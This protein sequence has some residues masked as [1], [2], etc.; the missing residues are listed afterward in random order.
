MCKIKLVIIVHVAYNVVELGCAKIN[1]YNH[2]NDRPN[3][4]VSKKTPIRLAI[5]T[6]YLPCLQSTG[7]TRSKCISVRHQTRQPK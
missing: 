4:A 3:I 2:I 6:Q 5:E 7:Y 1:N